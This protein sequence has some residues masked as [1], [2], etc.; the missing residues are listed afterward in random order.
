MKRSIDEMKRRNMEP[1]NQYRIDDYSR[2]Y[3]GR[4]AT[5]VRPTMKRYMGT[6][7]CVVCNI[8]GVQ[9]TVDVPIAALLEL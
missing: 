9:G 2:N 4:I 3:E 1:G 5:V 8:E 6:H 7:T